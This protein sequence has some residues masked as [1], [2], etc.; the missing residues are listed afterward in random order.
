VHCTQAK[1]QRSFLVGHVRPHAIHE[2]VR[3]VHPLLRA[4]GPLAAVLTHALENQLALGREHEVQQ[5][6]FFVQV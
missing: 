6:L 5:Q 2:L 4:L 1:H 3:S